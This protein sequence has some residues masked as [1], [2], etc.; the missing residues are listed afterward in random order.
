MILRMGKG[1][2]RKLPEHWNE[3]YQAHVNEYKQML[4]DYI[5][6][7]TQMERKA[8]G[9]SDEEEKYFLVEVNREKSI[10]QEYRSEL[11]EIEKVLG[12]LKKGVQEKEQERDRI[13]GDYQKALKE[14]ATTAPELRESQL[15]KL[16]KRL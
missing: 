6:Y 10:I 15:I 5:H 13:I 16:K 9:C 4:K 11:E 2:N 14:Y 12:K 1:E 7:N 3:M 8:C